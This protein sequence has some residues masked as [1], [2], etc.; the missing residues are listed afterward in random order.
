MR[1]DTDTTRNINPTGTSHSHK[2]D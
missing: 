1:I 2:C